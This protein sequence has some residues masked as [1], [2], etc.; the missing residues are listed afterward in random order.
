MCA[1]NIYCCRE[2]GDTTTN[3]CDNTTALSSAT[4][5][6]GLP[7]KA[8]AITETTTHTVGTA[9]AVSNTTCPSATEAPQCQGTS[10]V[11]AVGAGVGVALG[12]LLIASLVAL[13][14]LMRRQKSLR[15]GLAQA[16]V[17]NTS[18]QQ[19]SAQTWEE[20]PPNT[21]EELDAS[22]G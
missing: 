17:S 8:A 11:V 12:T 19:K 20:L 15:S 4:P 2:P 7:T 18:K 1:E 5:A 10:N 16:Q 21:I 13:V 6:I 14:V 9:G 22:K 3:C